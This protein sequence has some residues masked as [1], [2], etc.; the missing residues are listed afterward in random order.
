[1]AT[2]MCSYMVGLCT[3]LAVMKVESVDAGCRGRSQSP[4]T[5]EPHLSRK[6]EGKRRGVTWKVRKSPL[7][8]SY[9]Q[10]R[11][12]THRAT[13]INKHSNIFFIIVVL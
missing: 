4:P 7:V 5:A 9:L 11:R 1:M 12:G 3:P 6:G 2:A 10:Q 13:S 8:E